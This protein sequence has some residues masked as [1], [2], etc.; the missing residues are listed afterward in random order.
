[1]STFAE[2]S[3]QIKEELDKNDITEP[4]TVASKGEAKLDEN[5]NPVVQKVG[6]K[7]TVV[8]Q[9]G[10]EVVTLDASTFQLMECLANVKGRDKPRYTIV[11]KESLPRY[12]N[13]FANS[14]G[15]RTHVITREVYTLLLG[16]FKSTGK[17]LK[18]LKAT[19][20]RANEQRD[21]YKLTVDALRKNGVID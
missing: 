10:T 6:V 15:Q 21:L 14:K 17:Q 5:G 18:D 3:K 7:G 8:S 1:M 20:E 12:G 4:V 11:D 16:V 2:I 9:P 19:A 13:H